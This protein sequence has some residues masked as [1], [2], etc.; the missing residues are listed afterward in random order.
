M[1]FT[2]NEARQL[3][4]TDIVRKDQIPHCYEVFRR[5]ANGETVQ[6]METVYVSK[7]GR[8]I[9]VEGN[10]SPLHKDGQFVSCRGIFRDIT[11]RK[12]MKEQL[13]RITMEL[14]ISL[15]EV[16]EA[17]KK[18]SSGD[19]GVRISEKSEI[20]IISQLKH[21]INMT[22]ENIG[23]IVDQSHE[24]AMVLAEHFEVLHKVSAGEFSARVSGESKVE[25]LEA[26]KK[27]TNVMI[28]SIQKT[29][30][31][32]ELTA[33]LLKESEKRYR[34]LSELLPQVVFELDEKGNVIFVNRKALD[35]FGYTQ[36]DFNKGVNI[37]EMFIPEDRERAV[38]NMQ[39][40][41]KGEELGGIEYRALKK[42][43][44]IFTVVVFASPIF[45]KSELM[46]LRGILIDITERKRMEEEL[47]RLSV[48]DNLTQAYNRTKFEEVIKREIKRTKRNSRPLSVAMFDIDH[49]KEVNDAYGH[50]VGDY[51]LKTLSQIAQKNIRDIDY[52]IR[53]GGEEFIVIALDTDLRGAEVMAEKIRQAIEKYSFD[54]VGRVTVSF[55]VTQ[56]KQDDTED[57]FM[58]RAD[59]A[60]YQAKEKGRN[61]VEVVV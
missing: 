18:I 51:V 34:D 46:G 9:H 50:D 2:E 19:P 16:F 7:D 38:Q 17:L 49:F 40:R 21:M 45:R 60:L 30:T 52:L 5:V 56:F 6:G 3:H 23:E 25:L 37:I 48:T 54:K 22:A 29:I 41:F 20:E 13:D 27:V 1:G 39:S 24:F 36:A 61:R 12:M 43:G 42:D 44:G 57:S 58:K 28:E 8:E 14:S 4:F 55:G 15:S 10:I 33:A 31:E 35:L 59:D 11:E 47:K 53:W 26:F 32:R